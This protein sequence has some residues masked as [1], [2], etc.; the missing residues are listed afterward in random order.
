MMSKTDPVAASG[1]PTRIKHILSFLIVL[2]FAGILIAVT[3]AGSGRYTAPSLSRRLS[4]P[5]RPYL[6]S[7]FLG[8]SYRFFAPNPDPTRKLYFRVE[9][10]D[11]SVRWVEFPCRKDYST[12]FVYFRYWKMPQQIVWSF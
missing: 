1:P 11:G 12:M 5:F 2:H 8:A 6:Q 9:R 7:L 3:S 4:I 10:E